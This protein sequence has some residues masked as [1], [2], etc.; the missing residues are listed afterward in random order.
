MYDLEDGEVAVKLARTS[1]ARTVNGT[2]MP[3]MELPGKFLEKSGAFVT[4]N[5]YPHG[6][7]RGCIGYPQP[8]F[9]LKESL[10]KGAEGATRDPRFPPLGP[11]ELDK[12]VVEVSLLTLPER[13]QVKN[14]KEY[15]SKVKVGIHGLVVQQGGFKGLLLPQVP[16]EQGWNTEQFLGHTCMKAGLFSD[17]WLDP[18]TII[19]S[20][21]GEV[22]GEIEPNGRVERKNL[23]GC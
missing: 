19:Y 16:V 13:I 11:D 12:I 4:L 15:L 17:A 8:H 22:F 23:D 1:I 2:P 9:P 6:D 20:F 18:K 3:D 5:T 21:T 10:I 7:L 14:P